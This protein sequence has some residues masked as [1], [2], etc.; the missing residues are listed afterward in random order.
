MAANIVS[1]PQKRKQSS[2]L[3]GYIEQKIPLTQIFADGL[4]ARYLPI[5]LYGFLLGI[6][7]VGNTHYYERKARQLVILEKQIE[8]LR[9]EFIALKS[10][11]MLM[12]KQ[13][14]VAQRVAPIGIME[15]KE[16]PYVIKLTA[17]EPKVP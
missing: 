4:P 12:R 6:F 13:S 7:Y 9:V 17:Q 14:S 10:A 11:Y 15:A 2:G 8:T 16:P 3:F 5:I 1:Q